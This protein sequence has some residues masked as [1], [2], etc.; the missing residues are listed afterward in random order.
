MLPSPG[1]AAGPPWR[2][3]R[4]TA[5][6]PRRSGWP[7]SRAAHQA[8]PPDRALGTAPTVRTGSPLLDAHLWVKRPGESNGA[9]RGAPP[10]GH[11]RAAYAL[12]PAREPGWRVWCARLGPP[13][14]W[15]RGARP[16]PP[17][18]LPRFLP[19]HPPRL[20]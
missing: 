8:D 4:R 10:E 11:W 14:P 9:C 16:C 18:F 2:W 6:D 15:S 5:A 17:R 20:R 13:R 12:E 1:W 7:R 3:A 19:R